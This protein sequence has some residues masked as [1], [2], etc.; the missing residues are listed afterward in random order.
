MR[1]TLAKLHGVSLQ[2]VSSGSRMSP[3]TG[4]PEFSQLAPTTGHLMHPPPNDKEV[5]NR[6]IDLT[7]GLIVV[8]LNIAEIILISRI[9]RKKKIYEICILSLSVTDLLFGISNSVVSAIYLSKNAQ[10]ESILE[11]TYTTYFYFVLNSILHLIWITFDRLWLVLKPLQHRAYVS[12]KRIC[13]VLAATWITSTVIAA[14]LYASDKVSDAFIKSYVTTSYVN[15]AVTNITNDFKTS[16]T[17]AP[18]MFT[19]PEMSTKLWRTKPKLEAIRNVRREKTYQDTMQ[20]VLSVF[21]IIADV[22]LISTYG[23]IIY[24]LNNSLRTESINHMCI[25]CS[26]IRH[27]HFTIRASPAYYKTRT[28]MGKFNVDFKQWFK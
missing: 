22:V 5:M 6:S 28:I 10:N 2:S 12:R 24:L 13:I 19:L 20:L 26:Y 25:H 1:K 8:I 4:L 9:K 7:F 3:R 23:M 15:T 18:T 16:S 21:I 17:V 27:L 11:I 14:S